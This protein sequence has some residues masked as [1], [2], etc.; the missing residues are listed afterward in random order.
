MTDNEIHED[1]ELTVVWEIYLCLEKIQFY[2]KDASKTYKDQLEHTI[3]HGLV[4]LMGYDHESEED[5]EVMEW[6]EG[7]IHESIS[8]SQLIASS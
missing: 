5:A 7:E 1:D 4:H 2:A 3:I 6:I 8:S